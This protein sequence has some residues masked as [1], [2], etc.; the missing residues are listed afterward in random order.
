M[1]TDNETWN[2]FSNLWR[3][4]IFPCQHPSFD[5]L[6]H[7]L[8]RSYGPFCLQ[9]FLLSLNVMELKIIRVFC[10]CNHDNCTIFLVFIG[11]LL[12]SLEASVC[13]MDLVGFIMPNHYCLFFQ[14]FR[15]KKDLF[16]CLIVYNNP[17]VAGIFVYLVY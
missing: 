15:D 4:K 16:L 17:R 5:S 7:F 2:F 12:M 10:C 1:K 6:F 14:L 13:K 11:R 3:A 8:C 9:K